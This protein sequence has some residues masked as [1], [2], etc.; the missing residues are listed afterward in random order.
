MMKVCDICGE[1]FTPAKHKH[2]SKRC[3]NECWKRARAD[4]A[5][6]RYDGYDYYLQKDLNLRK[7]VPD[8]G[9]A[10]YFWMLYLQDSKCAICDRPE[11]AKGKS[12]AL[13][14]DHKTG[15]ARKL[16]CSSC[17]NGLGRFGDDPEL[18]RKGADY[19]EKEMSM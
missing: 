4:Q 12:L 14:H 19:L 5:N 13:D 16:L 10:E 1:N 17:N 2:R 15:K 6:S 8:F 11:R 3:S 9:V 18:M 7:L